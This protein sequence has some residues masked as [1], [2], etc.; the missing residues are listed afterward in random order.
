MNPVFKII[1]I[2]IRRLLE[3]RVTG[4]GND[5]TGRLSTTRSGR[6]CAEWIS[7]YDYDR[8]QKIDK[9]GRMTSNNSSTKDMS[10]KKR[11]MT[12]KKS[13]GTSTKSSAL[14]TSSRM[15]RDAESIGTT[16]R[17][18]SM[19]SKAAEKVTISKPT[20]KATKKV[21]T[22]EATQKV[23]KVDNSSKLH[24][25][26][27]TV[28]QASS[29]KGFGKVSTTPSLAVATR[30][31][32]LMKPIH[33]VNSQYFNDSLYPERSV[34]NA[35]NYCRDP[36]RNIAG[37]W[38]YTTDP[39]VPQDLCDVRDCDLPGSKCLSLQARFLKIT[40]NSIFPHF[41]FFFCWFF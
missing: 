21:S 33:S 41:H 17:P 11:P 26:N 1:R 36:S 7:D 32:T 20:S 4:T 35:S 13:L 16:S 31:K 25:K 8:L 39:L 24:E 30:S 6:T 22:S 38:C 28:D 12:T 2:G 14:K 15:T 37:T 18:S 3:C 29:P 23:P 27:V 5:Y 40:I 9:G 10:S 34:R 19:T